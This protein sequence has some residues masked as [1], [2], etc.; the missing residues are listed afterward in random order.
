MLQYLVVVALERLKVVFPGPRVPLRETA[1]RLGRALAA[2]AAFPGRILASDLVP[3]LL[4][5]PA[6]IA[7]INIELDPV[8]PDVGVAQDT[9]GKPKVRRGERVIVQIQRPALALEVVE[10]PRLHGLRDLPV[11]DLVQSETHA[12]IIP[13]R[14]VRVR[15]FPG[16]AII[17]VMDSLAAYIHVPYCPRKCAYC[18]FNAY[19]GAT[20]SQVETYVQAVSREIRESRLGGARV[21]T[22]FFGGGTPTYLTG[23]QLK[24][25]LTD[26]RASFDVDDDAEIS[27][28]A[29]PSTADAERFGS[30]FEAGFNRLSIGVQAFDD[31][32]LKAVDRAHSAEEAVAA[33]K[34][35][36]EAGFTN[37]SIDLMFGLP[38]Q[39]QE[40]WQRS[41]DRAMELGVPHLST[42]ALTIEPGTRFERLHKGGK[43]ALPSEEA[44]LAMYEHAIARLSDA[45]YEHYEVSNYAKP[46]YRSRHNLVYWRNEEY[47]GFG[48]GAVS[49][50]G[51]RRWTNEK[52]PALYALKIQQ[53]RDLAVDSET[54][55]PASAFSE[56]LIQGLRLREGVDLM[57]LSARF[58]IESEPQFGE[59]LARLERSG[60]VERD[61]SRVRLT[62]R[63]LLF[64]NDVAMELLV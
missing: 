23:G 21:S 57:P 8:G 5:F 60:L 9:V 48:P 63:G 42:Y 24:V 46:G 30:M 28:E 1:L 19:S 39:T 6:G 44:E 41:L 25:V 22:V 38:G 35:A 36:R 12:H 15:E 18:D 17:K 20:D 56:S 33:V 62:H 26:L 29:N 16:S 55:P 32:L 3:L 58:R 31:R 45:G 37:L 54:L 40:D 61:D 53:G 64:S 59:T 52:N 49:Y 7:N 4:T 34:L 11:R 27:A 10:L 50:V 14:I 51:G 43:L 2:R 13:S 47:V